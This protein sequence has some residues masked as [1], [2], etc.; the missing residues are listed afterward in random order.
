MPGDVYEF[1]NF[2]QKHFK[3]AQ[4]KNIIL[5]LQNSSQNVSE[6]YLV[7]GLYKKLFSAIFQYTS[8]SYL[9]VVV[10]LC[11]PAG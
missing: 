6:L 3:M 2:K 7:K 10:F 1:I 11:I 5:D 4:N 9:F 8:K